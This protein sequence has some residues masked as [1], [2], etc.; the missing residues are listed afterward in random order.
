TA[1]KRLVLPPLYA[2]RLVDDTKPMTF[3]EEF[4]A[5]RATMRYAEA[6][7]DHASGASLTWEG[8]AHEVER[9]AGGL[10]ALGVAR[11][12][13]VA[14]MLRTRPESN[15][16]DA[17]AMPLGAVPWSIYNTS[18]PNQVRDLLARAG[19]KILICEPEFAAH[20]EGTDVEHVVTLDQL[21]ELPDP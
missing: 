10:A 1:P 19:S 11:G 6:L 15:V 16:A 17:A 2:A 14:L 7:R 20:A 21:G 9:V 13:T 8:Y 4:Q 12:D 3:C 18:A 5:R